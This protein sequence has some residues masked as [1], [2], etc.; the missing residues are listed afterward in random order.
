[1]RLFQLCVLPLLLAATT[2]AQ[3]EQ[4]AAA[5]KRTPPQPFFEW[6]K[7]D[8]PQSEYAARRAAML[9]QLARIDGGVMLIPAGHGRS[10]GA[11]FRQLDDFLYFTGLEV[12]QSM[13][14]LDG[15][16]KSATLFLPPTDKRFGNIARRNDFPGRA[17]L[18]DPAIGKATG[19]ADIQPFSQLPSR[20]AAWVKS[21]RVL[22]VNPGRP[23]L[24]PLMTSWIGDASPVDHL[25]RHLGALHPDAN[26]QSAFTA[27][28]ALRMIKSAAEI[29]TLRRACDVTCKSIV[30]AA[31]AVAVGVDERT[32]EGVLELGFKKRGSQRRAFDSIIKSGPNSL[33]PWRIL[34][35]HYDRRN[36][37][38]IDGDLVIFDVGCE[39]N[40]YVTDVGRTFPANGTFSK[41]Q[42]EILAI[43]TSAADAIIA[44]AKPGVTLSQLLR[45]AHATIPAEHRR[46]MQTGSFFG[47]HVGLSTGDPTSFTAPLRPGMVFTVEPWYYNHDEQIAVFIE[48]MIVITE[49]GCENLTAQL[50]RSAEQLEAMMKSSTPK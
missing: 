26:V 44:A 16:A 7:L 34:A 14:V 10:H 50:P 27:I 30:E 1:M 15:D 9:T 17:L 48:D 36:R 11:T 3:T 49:D 47:H 45:V 43:S 20:V 22:L 13:L 21:K 33:W 8:F 41:R 42:R 2:L 19:I 37:A 29:E 28:A 4:P 23:R 38:M 46:Y 35:A 18:R 25:R 32:L 39:R 24:R 6:S 40:Y 31:H 12:P 5:K